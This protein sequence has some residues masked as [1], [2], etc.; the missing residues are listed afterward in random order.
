[1]SS[2]KKG[3]LLLTIGSDLF[4]VSKFVSNHPGEGIHDVYLNNY[5]RKNVSDEYEHYH[6]DNEPDEWLNSAKS[7]GFDP[8]TGIC[9]VGEIGSWF[10]KKIPNWFHFFPNEQAE[11]SFWQQEKKN[12]VFIVK[13]LEKKD[14]TKGAIAIYLD[15]EGNKKTLELKK[16]SLW[17]TLEPVST[18]E[19]TH[20]TIEGLVDI[21]F[22]KKGFEGL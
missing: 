12:K 20:A 2:R 10:K 18:T 9:Y 16:E 14:V 6:Y 19:I 22:I 7:K 13:T 8:E 17:T 3:E 1:M 4:E 11:D 5:N 21:L 15:E